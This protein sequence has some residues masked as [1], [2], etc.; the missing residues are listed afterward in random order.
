MC[1]FSKPS[2]AA[3]IIPA[4]DNGAARREADLEAE[5]R[6]RRAGAAANVLTSPIGI[7]SGIPSRSAPKLGQVGQP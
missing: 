3:P 5:L 7:P 4:P 6:R 1:F 2:V